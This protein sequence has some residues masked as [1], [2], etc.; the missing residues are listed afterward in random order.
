MSVTAAR[1]RELRDRQARER[2]AFPGVWPERPLG[3]DLVFRSATGTALAP[4]NVWSRL[5][6]QTTSAGLGHWHPHELRHSAA[7]LLLGEGVPLKVV[8]EMLGHSGINVT[9]NVHAHVLA[10]A[11]DEPAEAMDRALQR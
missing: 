9:A 6:K 11:R 3:V 2:D 7:S 5:S 1:L 8:S 4:S 10:P